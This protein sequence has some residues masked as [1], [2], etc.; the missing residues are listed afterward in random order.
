MEILSKEKRGEIIDNIRNQVR[1][2]AEDNKK[3]A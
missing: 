1:K 2:Y 3:R